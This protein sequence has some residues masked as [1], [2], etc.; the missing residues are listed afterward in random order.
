ME[1]RRKRVDSDDGE[2]TRRR[3]KMRRYEPVESKTTA[4]SGE[5]LTESKLEKMGSNGDES[6]S[7]DLEGSDSDL[8]PFGERIDVSGFKTIKGFRWKYCDQ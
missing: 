4:R 8:P 1:N 7:S 5:E 6:S 3:T 2:H